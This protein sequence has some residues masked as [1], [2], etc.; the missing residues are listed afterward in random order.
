MRAQSLQPYPTLC[1]PVD[2]SLP[3][4]SVH[5]IFQASILEWVAMHS[6]RGSSWPRDHTCVSCIAG[7]FFATGGTRKDPIIY[8]IFY[9]TY[10]ITFFLIAYIIFYILFH[11]EASLMAQLV[12][13][14]LATWKT[15]VQSLGGEDPLEKKMATHSSILPWRIPWTKEPAGL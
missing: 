1:D 3:V 9:I 4:S 8:I 6:S 13:S 15:Q 11:Y 10:I 5:G 2:H 7:R 12:K 14:L